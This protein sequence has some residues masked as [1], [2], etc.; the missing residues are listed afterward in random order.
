MFGMSLDHFCAWLV[1]ERH[2]PRD[3]IRKDL[4]ADLTKLGQTADSI[5]YILNITF[6]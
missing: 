1:A 3:L 4:Q 5:T 2:Q 6:A